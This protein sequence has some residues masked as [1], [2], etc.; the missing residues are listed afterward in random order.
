M[1]ARAAYFVAEHR[2]FKGGS[3]QEDWLLAEAQVDA[4]LGLRPAS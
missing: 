4:Q 1:I 2:G 3:A